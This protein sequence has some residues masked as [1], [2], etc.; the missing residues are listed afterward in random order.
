M[1]A[2]HKYP[3]VIATGQPKAHAV[4]FFEPHHFGIGAA[5]V[6]IAEE[7]HGRL[8]L[9][10]GGPTLADDERFNFFYLWSDL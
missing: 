3:N 9:S 1:N 7:N 5:M 6:L 8:F 10:M 2:S 4:S